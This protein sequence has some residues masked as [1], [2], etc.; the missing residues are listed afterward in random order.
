MPESPEDFNKN[1][2]YAEF[3]EEMIHANSDIFCDMLTTIA[4]RPQNKEKSFEN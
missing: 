4:N 2:K 1:P 3:F